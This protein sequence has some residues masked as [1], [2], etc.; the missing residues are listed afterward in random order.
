[1][2]DDDVPAG[3]AGQRE[4]FLGNAGNGGFLPALH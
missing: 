2:R 3:F 4:D 1:L